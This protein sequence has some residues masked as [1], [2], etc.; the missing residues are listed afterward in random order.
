MPRIG[1][2]IFLWLLLFGDAP[3]P[4]GLLADQAAA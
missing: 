1:F 3:R 4:A 2:G